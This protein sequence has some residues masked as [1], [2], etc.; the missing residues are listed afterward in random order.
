MT[1]SLLEWVDSKRA[2]IDKD[3]RAKAK[4]KKFML[5]ATEGLVDACLVMGTI[6][7]YGMVVAVITINKK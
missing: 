1:R 7:L 6:T 2:E 4:P 3:E 5:S